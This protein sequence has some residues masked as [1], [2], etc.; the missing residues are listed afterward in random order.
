MQTPHIVSR[1]FGALAATLTFDAAAS[2]TLCNEGDDTLEYVMVRNDWTF[3]ANFMP[4]QIWYVDGWH[5][6]RPGCETVIDE[7]KL[8]NVYLLLQRREG[9]RW[10]TLSYPIKDIGFGQGV[11][12][13][14]R[15][16]CIHTASKLWRRAQTLDELTMCTKDQWL[17]TFSVYVQVDA[18]AVYTLDLNGK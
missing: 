7:Q 8:L 2:L 15:R 1:L 14:D 18:N 9:K 6:L 13:T 3:D 5:T 11:T 10:R 12:G 16:F 4:S 17:E